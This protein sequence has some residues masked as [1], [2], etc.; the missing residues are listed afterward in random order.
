MLYHLSQN[1]V[2]KALAW[3]ASPVQE[4]PPRELEAL[5]QVEWFLLDRMLTALMQEREQGPV[6]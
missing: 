4:S 6:H 3:L 2:E 1:Q 5:N